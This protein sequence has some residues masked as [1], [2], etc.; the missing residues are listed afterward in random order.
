ME[1]TYVR[2]TNCAC[3]HHAHQILKAY[4]KHKD[5]WE[6]LVGFLFLCSD[7]KKKADAFSTYYI[8]VNDEEKDKKNPGKGHIEHIK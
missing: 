2:I 7:R 1:P 3:L 8:K 5:G 4:K 6:S